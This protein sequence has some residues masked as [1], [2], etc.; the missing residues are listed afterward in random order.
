MAAVFKNSFF[1]VFLLKKQ[2]AREQH[3]HKVDTAIKIL[4]IPKW[5]SQDGVNAS[6]EKK[7]SQITGSESGLSNTVAI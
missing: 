7:K 3:Q 5:C 1:F 6:G 2:I 4:I